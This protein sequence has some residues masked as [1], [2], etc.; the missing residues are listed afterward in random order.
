[1]TRDTVLI[2]AGFIYQLGDSA[3]RYFE[4]FGRGLGKF[5]MGDT[6]RRDASRRDEGLMIS[7]DSERVKASARGYFYV[8]HLLI[9]VLSL[10]VSVLLCRDV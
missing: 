2:E 10:K 4:A 6:V 9:D 8:G 7:P 1:M 5:G 3:I